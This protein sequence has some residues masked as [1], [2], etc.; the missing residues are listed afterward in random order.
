[1]KLAGMTIRHELPVAHH[2]LERLALEDAIVVASS[3]KAYGA[4]A[5]LPYS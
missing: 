3:D 5:K 2:A 1:M 4:Q